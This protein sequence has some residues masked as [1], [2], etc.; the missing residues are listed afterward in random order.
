MQEAQARSLAQGRANLSRRR[1]LQLLGAGAGIG[2][3]AACAPAPQPQQAAP[4]AAAPAAAETPGTAEN[5]LMR[6]SGTPKRGGTLRTAFGVTTAHYDIQ[7]GGAVAVMCQVYNNLV[8][9]N[10]V[11]G[12]RTVI[13]DLAE[14]W[15][16]AADGLTYTFPLRQGVK[17]HDG[18]PF[19]ADDVVATFNRIL[20]PPEG[21][22]MVSQTDLAMVDSV[23]KVDDFTVTFHLNSPRSYF[24]DLLAGTGMVIYSKKTL[25][26]NNYDLR[27]VQL[28]PGTGAFRFVEYKTAESWTFERNPDYWDS[29]LPYLDGIQ[30]LHVPAWSDRGTAVLTDQADLSWNVAFETWTEGEQRSDI[31]Q[32]NKLANFGAYWVV[33]NINKEPFGDPRV[34]KAINLGIS[35]QNMIKAFGSQ[36]QINLT[37]WI[38]YGDPFATDPSVLATMPGYRED[39]T[40]D[41]ATAK[42]LLADAGF[43]DGIQ[44]VE[45]LAAAGPQAEL[46]A[47]AFQDMLA[48]NLNIQT[49]IKIIERSQLPEEEK[50][51]NFTMVIDTPGGHPLSDISPRANLGWRTGGS[52]NWN[53]YSNPDFD[54]LLDQIDVEI[55]PTKRGE[56]IN[57]AMDL[58]DNDPPWFLIGYTF[59]LPMWRNTVKGLLL[60]DRIFAE[61]GHLE[62]VWLDV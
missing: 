39:K 11:D 15:E 24:L 55:D 58:L 47:P 36:E 38:P 4:A 26:E 7:Q 51:G 20:N 45:L 34:R 1:F 52:Q 48:R 12:L 57:Q 27:E 10:L 22:V 28:A 33:F 46:L 25:E 49:E 9:R 3:L 35:R 21:I 32:V 8:R 23:E 59:H 19:T 18:E 62:T 44:G 16:M 37:R 6:P 60:N 40:E 5:G 14:S 17:F 29:E 31:V 54:A 30:M 13:P 43:P 50:A 42:Q 56:L 41:I 61:W 53:G 2:V